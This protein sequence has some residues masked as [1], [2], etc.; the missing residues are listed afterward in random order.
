MKFSFK[1]LEKSEKIRIIVV[2]L[3]IV[4]CLLLGILAPVIFPGTKFALII[5]SS[6]GKFFNTASISLNFP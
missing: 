5:D 4:V 2:G 6:I 3:V 1:N